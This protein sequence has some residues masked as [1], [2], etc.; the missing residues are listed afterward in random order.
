MKAGLLIAQ[1]LNVLSSL[2][3]HIYLFPLTTSQIR[4]RNEYL[5]IQVS[6]NFNLMY[7]CSSTNRPLDSVSLYSLISSVYEH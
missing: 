4:M 2:M 3:S 5:A 6:G 7:V 1:L